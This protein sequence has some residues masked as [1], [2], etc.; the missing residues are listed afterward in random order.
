M[1]SLTHEEIRTESNSHLRLQLKST[2]DEP[3]RATGLPYPFEQAQRLQ[4]DRVHGR[5]LPQVVRKDFQHEHGRC[6]VSLQTFHSARGHVVPLDGTLVELLHE[7]IANLSDASLNVGGNVLLHFHV[8]VCTVAVEFLAHRVAEGP[9]ALFEG[10][11]SPGNQLGI[12]RRHGLERT[13]DLRT[14]RSNLLPRSLGHVPL[15]LDQLTA[16]VLLQTDQRTFSVHP[17]PHRTLEFQE[18]LRVHEALIV[19][20]NILGRQ[21]EPPPVAH[22]RQQL[23]Q[24]MLCTVAVD[25]I[26]ERNLR[27]GTNP[28]LAVVAEL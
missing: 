17:S 11:A 10:N 18:I 12:V 28:R 26:S 1:N 9:I 22:P 23:N 6:R 16:K 2:R 19:C 25:Y 20:V 7:A 5:S 14:V 21:S 15:V 13:R 4:R 8:N 24:F 27:S 3:L